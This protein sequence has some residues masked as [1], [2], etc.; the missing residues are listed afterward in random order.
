MCGIAGLMMR[1]GSRPDAAIL[2]SFEM[3]LAHRGPDGKGQYVGDGTAL[4]QTRLS[5]ID[6]DTGDQPM[7]EQG[8]DDDQAAVLVGNGEI[9]NYRELRDDLPDVKFATASDCEPPLYLYRK[10]SFDFAR[11]LRGM[12]AFAIYDPAPKRLVLT[13]DPFGIKPLY[14]VETADYFA[15]A[16]EIQALVGAGLVEPE[17]NTAARDELF[18]L[19]FT[20]GGETILAGVHRLAPG[21][22]IVVEGGRI[23]ERRTIA[24]LPAGGPQDVTEEQAL[25]RVED[26]LMQ[27][28]DFHQRAD[29]PYGMFLSGGIDS[30]ALLALMARLNDTPVRAYTAGFPGTNARDERDHARAVADAVGAE[31]IDVPVTEADFW[32]DLPAI[33]AAMD[34][35]AADYAI[36]PTYLLG[37]AAGADLKVVLTGEGGDELFGGYGRYRTAR[38]P[39]WL[40]GRPLR[41]RGTFDG[42][43][44]LRQLPPHWRNGIAAAETSAKIPGR[45]AL[46]VAQATDCAD[47]LPNDLLTK[48]DRCLMAHGLE[49]RVPFLDPAV[50]AVS[51]CLPDRLKI[52]GRMG[53]VLLRRWLDKALPVADAFSKKRG[54]TVPVSEWIAGKSAELGPLVAAQPGVLAACHETEVVSLFSALH[55]NPGDKRRGFAAWTILF[56]ALW[57]H[58]HILGQRPDGNVLETL[59]LKA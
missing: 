2:Q 40:G 18:Q 32:R 53:K 55:K 36:V 4:M 24:A 9:Y 56:Y 19:Q 20:T 26:A 21:E 22:T 52:E 42:M 44:I 14:Y 15:F 8:V 31:A 47:W 41:S 1:D 13:R 25:Q 48:A 51:F 54:F 16:S 5:I 34:D 7:F 59:S 12:Y 10:H 45:T 28:V 58:R 27:S 49:G 17:I 46:Q 50:V 30:S 37:R 35:P 3:S 6:L 57:H 29:V 33:A 38:R 39:R 43:D 23:I 11:H